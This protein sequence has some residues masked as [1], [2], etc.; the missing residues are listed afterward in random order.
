[1]Q[2]AHHRVRCELKGFKPNCVPA[3]HRHICRKVP[4]RNPTPLRNILGISLTDFICIIMAAFGHHAILV[5]L[6]YSN[7]PQVLL[8]KSLL[9]GLVFLFHC[10][11]CNSALENSGEKLYL[12][13]DKGQTFAPNTEYTPRVFCVNVKGD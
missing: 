12:L 4:E 9:L 13:Q 6:A 1:M 8:F 2:I 5:F 7:S 3:N 11:A 10:F